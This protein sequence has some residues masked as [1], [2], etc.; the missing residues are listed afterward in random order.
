MNNE[1]V[2]AYTGKSKQWKYATGLLEKLG[3]RYEYLETDKNYLEFSL[4]KKDIV[5]K[6]TFLTHT[7]MSKHPAELEKHVALLYHC[8]PLEIIDHGDNW[9]KYKFVKGYPVSARLSD[10]DDNKE[11]NILLQKYIDFCFDFQ[12]KLE[13]KLTDISATNVLISDDAWNV[14]DWDTIGNH[15]NTRVYDGI[16]KNILSEVAKRIQQHPDTVF[17]FNMKKP[18]DLLKKG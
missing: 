1:Y 16:C 8:T 12:S 2:N 7:P 3:C 17:N 15:N 18:S 11:Y 10:I 14:I 4:L 5:V 6:K 13:Y 9:I